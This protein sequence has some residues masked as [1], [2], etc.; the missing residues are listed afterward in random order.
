MDKLCKGLA[1][2]G[3][4]IGVGIVAAF[5]GN[6]VVAVSFFAMIATGFVAV[7]L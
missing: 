5:T 1:I 6:A 3:I 7:Y 2:I 4:W